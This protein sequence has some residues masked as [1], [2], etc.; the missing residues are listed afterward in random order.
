MG[1][2]ATKIFLNAKG[3]INDVGNELKVFLDYVAGKK[4]D[5]IFVDKLEEAVQKAKKNREWRHDYM[6]LIM[7]D[8]L[9]K[10]RAENKVKK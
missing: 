8:Q 9:N 5:D 2:E 7:R 1:D 4:S 10:K 6:T 3:N